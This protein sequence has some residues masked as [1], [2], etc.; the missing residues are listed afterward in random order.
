MKKILL[1]ISREYLTRVKKKS[2]WVLT[3][4]VPILVA[5]LYAVPILIATKPIEHTN[6]LVVDD[7]KVFEGMFS[8]SRNIT[9]FDAGSLDYAKKRLSDES[10]SISAIVYIPARETTIP[11]DAFLYYL[12]DIPSP[13]VQSD[14]EN[15]LQNLIRNSILLDVHGITEDEY[16]TLNTTTVKLHSKDLETGR[17]GFLEVKTIIGY[18]LAF[19]SFIVVFTFG[20]QV[21]RGVSEEKTSRIVE[22]LLTSVKPFQLMMGKVIGTGLVGLT[23]FALW[24]VISGAALG[25][26]QASNPDLFQQAEQR[27]HI[28]EVATKGTDATQQ[29]LEAEQS[30]PVSDLVQGLTA[31]NFPL[32]VGMF[33]LYFLLGY[34]FYSTLFAAVGSI[35]DHDTDSQQFT[36]PITIPL[37]LAF[38]LT[39]AMINE[40][41]G[42]LATWLSII[43]FTSPVAMLFRIPF[44]VPIVEVCASLV[45][46]IGFVPLN[47]WIASKIY[48]A[49]I[50]LYGKKITYRDI[51]SW[52]RR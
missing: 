17:D 21:M 34:L 30:A 43:P 31:I 12:S 26:I 27:Q 33:L 49:A 7:T 50:L 3:I 16:N 4:L 44:G 52:F 1:I 10:D 41:S 15:Q 6:L 14:I 23:Q 46:L 28:T 40:P 37:V 20:S 51:F 45:L 8:S 42:S 47:V 9:Y 25:G 5:A 18:V 35:V 2:F 48:K 24:I 22:V 29:L 38:L 39:P 13:E 11:S 19:L 32:I 36:L